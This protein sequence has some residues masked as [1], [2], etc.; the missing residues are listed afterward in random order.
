MGVVFLFLS[1]IPHCI[2]MLIVIILLTIKCDYD[3]VTL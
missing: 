2:Y 3:V 1:K